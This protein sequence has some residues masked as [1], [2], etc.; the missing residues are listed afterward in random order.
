MNYLNRERR[1]ALA[2]EYV[3]GTLRGKARDRYQKLMLEHEAVARTTWYW[4]RQL[5]V[6]S[7]SLP[8]QT[9]SDE[10]WKR[11]AARTFDSQSVQSQLA[12]AQPSSGKPGWAMWG[13]LAA[14]FILAALLLWTRLPTP[15]DIT[16]SA[17]A[18]FNNES[19]APLWLI[20][21]SDEQLVVKATQR[22]EQQN[23]K[24]YELWIVPDDNSAPV[25]LGVIPQSGVWQR[26]VHPL[27]TQNNVK[28]LA[29]SLEEKGG[30]PT[31]QPT[32]VLFTATLEST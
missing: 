25:S 29:V 16:P 26:S 24:D 2:A 21:V 23:A 30:S 15:D 19:Q 18:V 4:E 28:A 5:N 13:G 31:G 22:V 7:V 14:T 10:V 11:I 1:H 8:A 27:I 9:P 20:E 32:Q 6:L 17:V 3:L 12:T